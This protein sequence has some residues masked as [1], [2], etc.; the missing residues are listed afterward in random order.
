VNVA[1]WFASIGMGLAF[2]VLGAMKLV[3]SKEKLMLRGARWVD[4]LSPS[5]VRFVGLR[6]M[7][8]GLGMAIPVLLD[9]PPSLK[10]IAATGGLIVVMLGAA[11][12]HAHRR[13][14]AMIVWNSALLAL[15]AIAVWGG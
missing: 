14:P 1:F 5:T 12:V 8:A 13:E 9:I 11:V 6:E 10:R 7:V 15:A 4:D 2:A 3:V